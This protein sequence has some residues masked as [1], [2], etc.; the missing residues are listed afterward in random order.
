MGSTKKM[1]YQFQE[2]DD[3]MRDLLGGKGAGLSAMS[4]LGL[5]VP[6]G[7]IITTEACLWYFKSGGEWPAGLWE[8]IPV[9]IKELEKAMSRGFGSLSSP[10]L[11]SVRSGA[12]ISMPGMMDTILNLGINDDIV[13]G[14]GRLMGDQRP[15]LD[16]YR[17]FIQKYAEVVMGMQAQGFEDIIENHKKKLGV[18]LDH[19]LPVEQLRKMIEDFKVLIQEKSG[20][21]VPE[22][23]WEQ[24]RES[25]EA[26]FKSW[27]NPRAMYYRDFHG[28]S[29]DMGTAVTV[30]AMAF[31]NLGDDSGTGVL[32]TRNPASGANEI[33][34]EYLPNAQGEDVVAGIRTPEPLGQLKKKNPQL[35]RQIA[36]IAECLEKNY[37]DVQDVEFTVENNK[38]YL[39]QTRSAKRNAIASTKTA[40]D[41]VREKIIT[42]EEALTRVS[43]NDLMQLFV[44]R[45]E[46]NARKKVVREGRLMATGFGAS[47]G[48]ATGKAV[49]DATRAEQ[50]A[51]NGESVILVRPETNPDDVH[52]ILNATGVLTRRGGITSHAAV[53]TRGL[54]KPCVV[55]CEDL[56]VH[57]KDRSFQASGVTIHEGDEL[58]I[59]GTTGE[60]FLGHVDT[61]QPGLDE[62]EEVQV[63]L[64]WADEVR[65]LEVWANADTEDDAK[66][67]LAMGAEGIGL[68]RTE[69]MFLGP[70]RVPIVQQM[71]IN[72]E[73]A[74]EWQEKHTPKTTKSDCPP[75]VSLFNDALKRLEQLQID[76]FT[77]ILRVMGNRPVI[78]RLLD[79]PLHEFLP[80]HD[81]LLRDLMDLKLKNAPQVEIDKLE[82]LLH[83]VEPLRESNPMLGHRGCRVGI[84]FP[85]IYE[86]QVRAIFTASL[87]LVS[88]GIEVRPE[89]MIPMTAHVNE[90]RTLRRNLLQVADKIQEKLGQV[91]Y[92]FGTMIEVP[93]AALTAA[94]IAEEADF[95]S[96]GT[97]DLT[98]TTFG[99]SRDDAE[100]K[101][102]KKYLD[103]GILPENPFSVIDRSGVGVLINT[104]VEAGRKVRNNLEVGIC[105][106][107]GG[108]PSS[109]AFCHQAA[110]DYVSCSPFRVPVARLAAA[111]AALGV[112]T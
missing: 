104:A 53:V 89:I 63:L 101:F 107:H 94:E 18:D 99:F 85:A 1:L 7:F 4:R 59:D 68:C 111:Q 34:G 43:P 11:V 62:V 108:D 110:L 24:L 82:S 102:L 13:V 16:A 78:I 40:V 44:P 55:G 65:R 49:L 106:E 21:N 83:I 3:T 61:V 93:R 60:V 17:R 80:Q 66:R 84:T 52:G 87:A 72:A 100:M 74:Q 25:I 54:G 56:R 12:K 50:M 91:T 45:F 39:L 30:M 37:R 27:K 73:A 9:Y 19:K 28:I 48:A 79:A 86:M 77:S 29:H 92:L 76:D 31:G 95:F 46:A 23:P 98:Q 26:V 5:R 81:R 71:L 22:D 35:Y 96:F 14:L 58:S 38:L 47:P 109:I 20:S 51:Q 6:P 33:Y 2:G 64:G 10:M 103:D 15:A 88:Q 32:F 97:N 112:L 41:M 70:E 69:H 57:I 67:A 8:Q 90:F 105:G 42:K 75:E 36:E